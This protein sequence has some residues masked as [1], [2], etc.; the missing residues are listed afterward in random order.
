MKTLDSHLHKTQYICMRTTLNLPDPLV[1]Q[2]KRRALS[3]G[4]TLTDLIVKGLQSQLE[5]FQ[6]ERPLPV[7]SVAGGLAFGVE[8][9]RL[10]AAE[11]AGE[12][13]R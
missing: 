5:K 11:S 13:Y 9:D 10:E 1:S 7:C 4:T 8:W 3:E 2:A 12:G 6:P